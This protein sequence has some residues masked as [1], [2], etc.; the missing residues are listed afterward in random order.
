MEKQKETL[1]HSKRKWWRVAL[2]SWGL[3][4]SEVWKLLLG[5]G[6]Q[7]PPGLLPASQSHRLGPDSTVRETPDLFICIFM[8]TASD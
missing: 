2:S 7:V 4:E 1:D 5:S 8:K 3:S 6:D